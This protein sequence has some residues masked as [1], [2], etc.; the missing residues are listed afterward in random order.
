MRKKNKSHPLR[1]PK[2]NDR[3]RAAYDWLHQRN[4]RPW[5]VDFIDKTVKTGHWGDFKDLIEF[6][7]FMGW[8]G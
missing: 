7:R 5:I 2:F 3:E 8:D 6:A 4:I 1:K